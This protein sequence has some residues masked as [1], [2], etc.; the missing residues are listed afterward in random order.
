M[1]QPLVLAI[2]RAAAALSV[3][4]AACTRPAD[5]PNEPS[6]SAL[7]AAAEGDSLPAA[8]TTAVRPP[9]AGERL[10]PATFT[11]GVGQVVIR[12]EVKSGP[13]MMATP[14]ARRAAGVIV[15]RVARGGDPAALCAPGEVVY[16]YDITVRGV[17]PGR[18][19]VRL[20]EQPVELPAREVAGGE[21]VVRAP[22]A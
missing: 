19:R 9:R 2:R 1:T 10:G 11:G 5:L 6:A 12:W 3:M 14:D 4:L 13:C 8:L 20:A 7:P 21:V 17:P 16:R 15:V 22:D 18:Y